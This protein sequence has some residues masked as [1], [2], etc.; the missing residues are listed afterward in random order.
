MAK[1]TMKDMTVGSPAKIILGFGI[2]LLLGMLFQQFYSMADALI[3]ARFLGVNEFAAVGST[4]PINFM[5][6]GFCMGVCN[7]FAIPIAQRFGAGDYK[8]LRKYVANCMW[9]AIIVAVVMTIVVCI[10][11]GKIL[12]IMKTP[13]DI[14]DD[15]YKYIFIIFAGIP[16]MILYNML[17]GIIR[18]LGDSKT[19]LIF[20]L[21]SSVLNILLDLFTI[22]VLGTGVE[23][24]A[25][26]TVISQA[27]SGIL[28]LIYMIKK[29]DILKIKGDEWRMEAHYVFYLCKM[30]IPMGLQYSITAIGSVILQTAVNTLG[31]AAVASVTA[32]GKVGLFFCCPFDALGST[33][34]TFAG[35][36]I[37]AGKTKRVTQGLKA[38]SA[39]GLVYAIIACIVLVLFG[40]QI[41]TI[42]IDSDN[43]S[44]LDNA[45]LLLVCNS[46]F[47]FPLALVN[48]VRFAIQGV[49]YSGFAILAGVCEMIARAVVGFLFVP[50][51]GFAAVCAASP[52]AWILADAFLIP[53][54]I[55]VIKK[56]DQ[57][58]HA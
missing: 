16:V 36:N 29:F 18:A 35:Q 14:Y 54:Y 4:G 15:A 52:A 7:G 32:A 43:S 50:V 19:P 44:I 3:V 5:I 17:S 23:G 28:C 34:A 37:G 56:L 1:N 13:Y 57:K 30:G 21:I 27:V 58:I 10:F 11:C 8:S 53:A 49:G 48:V 31:S 38:S 55:Y 2:P 9:L 20:L 40:K 46:I 51:F 6:L 24:A 47:Y 25:Y 45:W 42:F 39:M 41:A 33:M 26:A 22:K 12:T